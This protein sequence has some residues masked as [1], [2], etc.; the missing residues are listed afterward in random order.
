MNNQF[1]KSQTSPVRLSRLSNSTQV[2]GL[3][4]L[5]IDAQSGGMPAAIFDSSINY[6]EVFCYRVK[7]QIIAEGKL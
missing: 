2:S 7:K 6:K 4:T 1:S 3:D 5:S